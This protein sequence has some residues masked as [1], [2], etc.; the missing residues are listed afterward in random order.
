M[1]R[2]KYFTSKRTESEACKQ[3]ET[4]TS[5]SPTNSFKLG[6][7]NADYNVNKKL[8]C[9]SYFP[10]VS[11]DTQ[12]TQTPMINLCDAALWPKTCGKKLQVT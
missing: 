4:S 6:V 10:E 7:T 11:E 3:G 1:N 5:V 2:Q 8:E 9:Q 12:T